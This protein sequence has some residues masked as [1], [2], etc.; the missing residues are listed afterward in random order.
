LCIR[1][2]RIII[3]I[4][5]APLLPARTR[6][7][8]RF[9]PFLL[10][11]AAPLR[12]AEPS[13]EEAEFFEKKV[14]PLLANHCYE[15]HSANAEKLKAGLYLDGR[16]AMLAGTEK[17]PVLVPG[18]PA[19]SRI[20]E[21]INYRN[22]DLQMPPK[23]K[24][25]DA[26]IADL[27]AWVKMGAPW[28]GGGSKLVGKGGFDLQ[29]RKESHWAWQSVRA[30]AIPEVKDH[31][32]PLA[33]S[34]RFILA[35]LEA[36]GIKPA[37]P[38]EAH[39]LLRRIYFDLVGLPPP[40]EVIGAFEKEYATKPQAALEKLVDR[41]LAS[42]QFGE[43]WARHWLDLVRYAESRG[44][45]FDPNIPN[46]W[47]YRDYVI[48][49]LNADVPYDQFVME[50]IA[51]DL[52]AKP[53]LGKDGCNES[54]LGTGFWF[55]GEEVHSPVDIRGDEADR[56]DNRIDVMTKTFLGL[57]V[58]CARCH[59]H[60]F[61]AISTKDYY[62]LYGFLRSSNYRLVRIDNWEHNRRVAAQLT[63]LRGEF[64]PKLLRAYSEAMAPALKDVAAYLLAARQVV[65]ENVPVEK[66]AVARSKLDQKRLSALV[67]RLIAAA[68][69]PA[70]PLHLWAKLPAEADARKKFLFEWALQEVVES[71]GVNGSQVVVD[72]A[73][74]RPEDWFPDDV[75][76]GPGPVRP[77]DVR[78][79]SDPAHP[80]ARFI[81][82]AA[83]ERDPAW[84]NLK[85]ASGAQLDTGALG[86]NRS[87]FTIRTPT[88]GLTSGKVWYLVKGSGRVYASVDGHITIAGPLHGSLVRVIGA[89]DKFR[90]V[91][92]DLTPYKG[93]RTH[94]EFTAESPDFAVAKVA[95]GDAPPKLAEK[96]WRL[97]LPEK[98]DDA[99]IA[100]AYQQE[101][102]RVLAGAC[103]CGS[104]ANAPSVADAQL[105]GW[106]L[107]RA[108]LF[109]VDEKAIAEISAPFMERLAEL[110]A[111]IKTESRLTVAMQ[112]GSP[113]DE[114]VFIRGS[115]KAPG[116]V[117]PRHLL[118]AL[119]G[120]KPIASKSGS[121]RL[122][123]ARQM[124][125]PAINPLVDRVI[126]N[127]VWHHLFGRGIV[128]ST[129]NF[130]V[131]GERPTH[132]ELLDHLATQFAHDGRSLKRL[133]R[134]LV[135]SRAYQMSSNPKSEIHNPQLEDP[136]NLLLHRMRLRRLEGEA[137]RDAMLSIS[138]RLNETMYGPSV[139]VFL[140]PFLDGRGKPNSGP[141][142]GDS[143][144]SL[145][146][147][148]RRNFL[149]PFMLAFDTPSPFSTVGR[150]TV[151]N[152]PAQA[153]IL[154]N[155]P[156]VHLM[157]EQWGKRLVAAPGSA[158]QRVTLMYL[159]AFS[160]GPTPSDLT[161]C[162]AF[163]DAR[164]KALGKA[165]DDPKSWGE[166][167]HVLF[168]V[169]SFIF[170]D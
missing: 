149:S 99:S 66:I 25:P 72:Y 91:A 40:V 133:I 104:T 61:D 26:A 126:V 109:A 155:D 31:P 36:K 24:L 169:K 151:S 114:A 98:T 59:D 146:I 37:P 12:A 81:D 71:G 9:V 138:G 29:K 107:Q 53:R 105:A 153:L 147:A 42:P 154:M 84:S 23:G 148:P 30:P 10:L 142:D 144:R 101:F 75:S 167:A 100:A 64:Q 145:Y 106:M 35:K 123:L 82:Y 22:A 50:H 80:I 54:I 125:D 7:M 43:R 108:D 135:L 41:L 45:E 137:I 89:G 60:K 139:P 70:D 44:H 157:A 90:W 97:K 34:D 33:N 73:T 68:K 87:G 143:R 58:S 158:E 19:K 74:S 8:P 48:R 160:R 112:D 141:L 21:A 168:N 166:L 130:G 93:H 92:H 86:Y 5:T 32:W 67:M 117:V 110:I 128:A 170:I 49:A 52:L 83:A 51:G 120:D 122:E 115:H 164:S 150:R 15:C 18:G 55:L 1:Y 47:Q 2:G 129:D 131:M 62:A 156:F 94:L 111:S 57:T 6:L 38:A 20:I 77:G 132:P 78:F 134:L 39:V 3:N 152:V 27:T 69:D 140:T 88:F 113:E 161:D 165:L 124:T 85:F 79:S 159:Q 4:N 102:E 11:L 17:G 65:L 13:A 118:T 103:F 28:P 16:D 162:L 163:V 46:A 95:V 76:F 119:A 127:R 96:P 136:E 14:R 121:G 116:A 63:A 56:F